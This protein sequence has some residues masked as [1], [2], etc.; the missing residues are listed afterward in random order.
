MTRRAQ[1]AEE[2]RRPGRSV[3]RWRRH[4]RGIAAERHRSGQQSRPNTLRR[5]ETRA[6]IG[7]ADLSN[8]Y[9]LRLQT[10]GL[11]GGHDQTVT[12]GDPATRTFTVLYLQDHQV[13]ALDCVNATRDYVHGHALILGRV[14]PDIASLADT[15]RPL[16]QLITRPTDG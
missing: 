11:S 16:K 2:L 10:V 14:R 13:I 9:D 15:E 5:Q 8:Q 12:R 6:G 4:S 3:R 7:T 1:L